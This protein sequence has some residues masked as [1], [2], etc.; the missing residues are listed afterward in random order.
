MQG[1]RREL[2][3]SKKRAGEADLWKS[4]VTQEAGHVHCLFL[5]QVKERDSE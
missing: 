3:P 5:S 2:K 1:N 4:D